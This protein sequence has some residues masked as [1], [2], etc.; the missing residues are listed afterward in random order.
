MKVKVFPGTRGFKKTTNSQQS[1]S[2]KN[3][4]EINRLSSL[5]AK[6]LSLSFVQS[7]KFKDEL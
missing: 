1:S 5:G 3:Y 2:F 6:I 7:D 4:L